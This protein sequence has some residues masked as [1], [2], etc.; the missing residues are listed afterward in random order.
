MHWSNAATK[1]DSNKDRVIH[2]LCPIRLA[3]VL[4]LWSIAEWEVS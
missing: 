3:A 2:L 1:L 4:Y